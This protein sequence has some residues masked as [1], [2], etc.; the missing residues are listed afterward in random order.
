MNNT[1]V[2]ITFVR[3]NAVTRPLYYT[4]RVRQANLVHM[5]T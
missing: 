3:Y 2:V 5:A 1:T 4:V